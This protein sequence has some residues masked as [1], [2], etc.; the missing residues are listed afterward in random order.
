MVLIFALREGKSWGWLARAGVGSRRSAA[1]WPASTSRQ[2]GDLLFK[3][4]NVGNLSSEHKRDYV[5]HVQMVFQDPYASLNPQ[6]A[7]IPDDFGGTCCPRPCHCGR[8]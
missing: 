7:D 2:T 4:G 1:L 5:R 6:D 8:R 3:G